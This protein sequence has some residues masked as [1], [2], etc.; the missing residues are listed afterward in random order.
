MI[1]CLCVQVGLLS[2]GHFDSM[3]YSSSDDKSGYHDSIA[4]AEE[5]EVGFK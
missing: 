3:L 2:T 5:E 1:L 4:P